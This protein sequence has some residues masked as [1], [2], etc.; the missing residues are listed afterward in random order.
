M[1]NQNK[2]V[3]STVLMSQRGRGTSLVCFVGVG[4]KCATRLLLKCLMPLANSVFNLK[5]LNLDHATEWPLV[6]LLD[7][8]SLWT[9]MLSINSR[10]AK[11]GAQLRLF[12]AEFIL[13]GT[14]VL[15]FQRFGVKT[16]KSYTAADLPR[17]I[18][19]TNPPINPLHL[20]KNE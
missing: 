20:F 5:T 18:S 13:D 19:S 3:F 7:F 1:W 11:C 6:H 4:W 2:H 15:V 9:L 14:T 8:W 17:C 16:W 12:G 10:F